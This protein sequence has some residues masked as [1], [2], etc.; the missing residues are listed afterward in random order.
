[1]TAFGVFAVGNFTGFVA[2]DGDYRS[3]QSGLWSDVNTWERNNGTI[4]IYPAPSAPTSTDSTI[5]IQTGHTV[6]VSDS[7]YA[8]QITV[9]TGGTL[10]IDSAKTLVVADGTGTDLTFSARS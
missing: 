4:W 7:E 2:G 9:N 1:M 3:H 8:D 6:E 5:A 10:K